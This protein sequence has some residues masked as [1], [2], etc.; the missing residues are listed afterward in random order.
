METV[1]YPLLHEVNLAG[2]TICSEILIGQS[3]C[4]ERQFYSFPNGCS[5]ACTSPK[6]ILTSPMMSRLDN[7]SIAITIP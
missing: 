3:G 5:E 2:S 4:K 6:V 7:S 1:S